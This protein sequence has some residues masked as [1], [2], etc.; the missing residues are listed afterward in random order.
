MGATR[1]PLGLCARAHCS[2]V[3][4]GSRTLS[5]RRKGPEPLRRCWGTGLA[6]MRLAGEAPQ[7]LR[8]GQFLARL[9]LGP[10]LRLF[11]LGRRLIGLEL[12]VEH[13]EYDPDET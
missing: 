12:G 6:D 1:E 7:R 9:V 4:S 11:L 3:P 13:G 8:S 2:G 10:L 5:G